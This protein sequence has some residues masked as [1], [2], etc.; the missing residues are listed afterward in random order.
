M[1]LTNWAVY[2][3]SDGY[4][5]NTIIWDK[6]AAPDVQAIDGFGFAE[7]PNQGAHAGEWSM[8]GVG[9][10]YINDQFVEPSKPTPPT[11]EDQPVSTG[12]QTF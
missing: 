11:A 5:E 12:V 10:S 9:W 8:C 4:I 1:A 3:L 2:R 6:D 7:I